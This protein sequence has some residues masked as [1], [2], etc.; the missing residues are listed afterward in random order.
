MC[1]FI[2]AEQSIFR[3]Y[4]QTK[5]DILELERLMTP[6]SANKGHSEGAS[7]RNA[8]MTVSDASN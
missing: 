3:E 6:G 7:F 1:N 8:R 4:A 5:Q 2:H